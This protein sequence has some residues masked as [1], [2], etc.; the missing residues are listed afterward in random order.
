MLAG[1]ATS[2]IKPNVDPGR[3]PASI[4]SPR[5]QLPPP[6]ERTFSQSPDLAF[7]LQKMPLY[8]TGV[9]QFLAT[10]P[11]YDGR[12]V[13][14][15]ILDSGIDGGI[16]GLATTTTGER[17]L[18]DLR[19]FSGEGRVALSRVVPSRDT[20]TVAGVTLAGFGRVVLFNAAGPWYGGV[21]R[22][23]P[24]GKAP[25]ADVDGNGRVG[26]SLPVIVTR[27]SDGWI[28]MVDTDRNGSLLGEKPVRDYLVSHET[29]S[30]SSKGA[31]PRL[32]LAAN[33]TE[34]A[35]VPVLDLFFDTSGHG[36]HVAGIAAG[37]DMYDVAGF[38]GVAPGAQLLGL[39]IAN[40]AQGGLSTSGSM[41]RAMDYAIR[42]AG[43]RRLPLVLN[44]SFAVGNE[45]EGQARIDQLVD[46]VLALHPGLVFV[47]SAGNDGPGLST[48]GMPGSAARALAVGAVLPGD[49]SEPVEARSEP[50]AYYSA[51]GGEIAK[52]EVLA[53][54]TAYSTVPLW[55]RG[56]EVKSGT[57]MA[58]P[59]VAGLIAL[60]YSGMRQQEKDLP[61]ARTIRQALMVT[62]R[63]IPGAAFPD[64]GAGIPEIAAAWRWLLGGRT[65]E[66]IDVR[67]T[68]GVSGAFLSSGLRAGADPQE[69]FTLVRAG[70]LPP[71]TY[72]LRSNASWLV[73][74]LSVT[75]SDTATTVTLRYRSEL[76]AKLGTVTGVV[77]G[78][79]ADTMAGPAFRLVSTIAQAVTSGQGIHESGAVPILP[80]EE[81]RIFIQADSGRPFEASARIGGRFPLL[82][83]LHE[84]SG[85]A[86][87]GSEP[88]IAGA[89]QE[90]VSFKV[91]GRDVVA[92]AYELVAVAPPTEPSSARFEVR[93]AP[94][95]F[96]ARREG[97]GVVTRIRSPAGGAERQVRLG[98]V[99]G[100][101]Q[102]SVLGQGSDTVTTSFVIPSWATHLVV[103]VSMSREQ[104]LRF[105]D[106]GMTLFD[107]AG[108]Q[109]ENAPLDYSFGRLESPFAG[110][111]PAQSVALRLFPAL[112]EPDSRER[113]QATIS[114]RLYADNEVLLSSAHGASAPGDEETTLFTLPASPWPL[115]E[116]FFPLAVMEV[117]QKGEVWTREVPLPEHSLPPMR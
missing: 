50:V 93:S 58:A 94:L 107:S 91:D 25:A 44:M 65:A 76:L 108:R 55:D 111:H 10:H 78:W 33:I 5:D 113:W 105:T 106:F 116:D 45:I 11:T 102:V 22:E 21:L 19:D 88:Q 15:A 86:L 40:N 64:Q 75:L 30:W 83:F 61:S 53:P 68:S 12:G 89:G 13:L 9:P 79:P 34:S 47:L 69:R 29:F 95:S 67:A 70:G 77:A 38:N 87:R 101:R 71:V 46:S 20:V 81:R 24:L 103:D 39:K 114:I 48:L 109:I 52:P 49:P 37:R 97:D 36:S 27:A 41:I 16:P 23:L 90:E 99:G 7:Q 72:A 57:S 31:S 62:A 3:T 56:E 59:H 104:W 117:T 98:L 51:R 73:A 100:E 115:G 74:P 2:Q 32:N 82:V 14:I 18:L 92:G 42:F 8:T 112:A 35:G 4:E 110:D 84:P 60:L 54:G 96:D 85:M 1:C 43:R 26:D 66:E 6:P 17:K 63:P 28:V 80:G